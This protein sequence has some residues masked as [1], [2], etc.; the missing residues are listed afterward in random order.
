MLFIVRIQ[1]SDKAAEAA[2]IMNFDKLYFILIE[3][4]TSKG[5]IFLKTIGDSF[6]FILYGLSSLFP[7]RLICNEIILISYSWHFSDFDEIFLLAKVKYL[8]IIK[9]I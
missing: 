8:N 2:V 1:I 6:L 9:N 3:K 7:T 4:I 5:D